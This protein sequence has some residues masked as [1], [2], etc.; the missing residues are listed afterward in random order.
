VD[1]PLDTIEKIATYYISEIQSIDKDGPYALA[2]FS[3]G[4]RIAYEM[5]RQLDEMGKK[6]S[7]LGVLDA[8]AEGSV[9][10][11]PF[12]QRN[13][14][15]INYFM[16]Y[17]SWNLASF[18][19]EPNETK[20]SVIRRRWKGLGKRIRGLDIKVDKQEMVSKGTKNELPKYLRK[21]HRANSRA[22][23]NYVIRPYSGT[24]HLFKAQK[25]TFYIPEPENYGWDRVAMGGVHVHEIPGEHSSTFAPPNDKYFAD[26]L[27]KTLD[28]SRNN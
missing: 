12:I 27:Q 25:Q 13:K 9:T 17:V 28:Q 24:V 4:G 18:F 8:T 1:E 23:R 14:Y 6:V 16:N 21:V 5:A 22:N 11:H 15:R 2:G 20:L 26:I 19:R 3:L 10:H 7:F